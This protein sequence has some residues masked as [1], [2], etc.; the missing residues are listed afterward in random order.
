MEHVDEIVRKTEKLITEYYGDEDTLY[1]FTSDHGMTNWGEK[2]QKMRNAVVIEMVY[3]HLK[4]VG[5]KD[6]TVMA[7]IMKRRH[8]FW[9]G[10]EESGT[11]HLVIF[12]V[13]YKNEDLCLN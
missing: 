6:L 8:H 7:R 9:S 12:P 5:V 11:L 3:L 10:E 2:L 13:P 4:L 1:V